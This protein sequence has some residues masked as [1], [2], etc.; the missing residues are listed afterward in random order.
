MTTATDS[1]QRVDRGLHHLLAPTPAV[2]GTDARAM[3]VA[4]SDGEQCVVLDGDG[5]PRA[6][7]DFNGHQHSVLVVGVDST[8]GEVV[9][10]ISTCLSHPVVLPVIVVDAAGS[11]LGTVGLH[12]LLSEVATDEWS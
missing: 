12:R 6:I 8:P 1:N 10:L 2:D 4:S 7:V 5:F 9:H 11:Y 3:A